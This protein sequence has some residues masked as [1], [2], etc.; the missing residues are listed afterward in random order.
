MLCLFGLTSI[1]RVANSTPI[2]DFDSRLT[3]FWLDGSARNYFSIVSTHYTRFALAPNN[4]ETG[5]GCGGQAPN[6]ARK[7]SQNLTAQRKYD[8]KKG[9][10]TRTSRIWQIMLSYADQPS[11][12]QAVVTRSE[13]I[14][15][16]HVFL[17]Q[18]GS[19]AATPQ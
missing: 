7:I 4:Q 18:H 3:P 16:K 1:L 19:I 5:R 6:R 8:T 10:R 11:I 17:P 9:R 2:V 12:R 13:H 14:T 15:G